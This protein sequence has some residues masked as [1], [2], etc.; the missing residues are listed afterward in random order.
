MPAT[1][2]GS[3]VEKELRTISVVFVRS[4]VGLAAEMAVVLREHGTDSRFIDEGEPTGP[5]D[6]LEGNTGA[7]VLEA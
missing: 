7:G 1:H 4:D 3:S 5:A 6:E 2:S